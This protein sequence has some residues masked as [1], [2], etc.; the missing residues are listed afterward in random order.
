MLIKA[1]FIGKDSLGYK[2]GVA[3][4]L[5]LITEKPNIQIKRF[6]DFSGVCEYESLKA[7]LTNW[8]D[9]TLIK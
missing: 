3:Y 6:E 2:N 1:T 5:Y 7:F 8:K 9:V 4:T